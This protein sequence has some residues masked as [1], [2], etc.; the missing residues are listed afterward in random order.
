MLQPPTLNWLSTQETAVRDP[1][2]LLTS[3]YAYIRSLPDLF[4]SQPSLKWHPAQSRWCN[5]LPLED[6]E[7]RKVLSED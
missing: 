1:V 5:R 4:Y 7:G 6:T 3:S 2:D